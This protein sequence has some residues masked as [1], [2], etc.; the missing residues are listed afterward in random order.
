MCCHVEDI[1]HKLRKDGKIPDSWILRDN[2]S[3]IN[4]F[5]NKYLLRN[6]QKVSPEMKIH[7][8]AGTS[9]INMKLYGFS[10]WG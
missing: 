2:Q 6:I 1:D 4:V 8:N 9:T 7:C 5:N 3:T 10:D